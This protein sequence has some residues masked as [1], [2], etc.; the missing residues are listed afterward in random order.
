MVN[1][2]LQ[3]NMVFREQ[4]KKILRTKFNQ[5]TMEG[6]KNVM[7]KKDT[8]FISLIMFYSSKTINPIKLYRLLSCVFYSVI[9]NCVCIEYLCCQSK[10]LSAISSDKIF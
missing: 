10:T 3:V 6:I 2:A 8:C 7:R 1:L 9:E 5:N 4:V